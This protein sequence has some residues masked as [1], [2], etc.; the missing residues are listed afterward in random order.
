MFKPFT[1][2]TRHLATSLTLSLGLLLS[3][4]V[5]AQGKSD[6][7]QPIEISSERDFFDL[8][9]NIAV[10]D[11][12]VVIRQGSLEIR[13]DNLRV[14]RDAAAGTDEFIASGSPAS[15]KQTLEDGSVIEA[16]A[17]QINYDQ[18]KQIITLTGKA[19]VAQNN[20]VI[21]GNEIIYNFATQQLSANRGEDS[22]R[23]TTIFMPKK[24]NDEPINR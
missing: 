13:A 11:V 14:K 8:A 2:A 7:A 12:N 24:N 22:E 21:Q 5:L 17:E 3:A 4:A 9:N 19:S 23:V 15:Y 20:S 1:P 10:F 16:E 18:V 6:F